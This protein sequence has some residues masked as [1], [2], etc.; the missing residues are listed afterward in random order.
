MSKH[1]VPLQGL[2]YAE[3]LALI[4]PIGIQQTVRRGLAIA[5][6][7]TAW[8]LGLASADD[9]KT[10][11]PIP[12]LLSQGE[13]QGAEGL[14]E[15]R[16]GLIGMA[17]Q[18][19]KLYPSLRYQ[20]GGAD[21]KKGG[22]DCSGS[23]YYIL[24]EYGL[25]PPRTSAGQ[26]EWVKAAGKLTLVPEGTTSLEAEVFARLKPGDLLFWSGTYTPKDGRSNK[27][28]H[29]QMY[30]GREKADGR[31]VMI[32]A[33]DG[34]SYRGIQRNGF[35]VFDFRLPRKGSKARIVGFGSPPG[36]AR[37]APTENRS[38]RSP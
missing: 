30:L 32:G 7:L 27:I 35:G 22:F 31:H 23:M 38:L 3:T 36:L 6:A 16:Q 5:I 24:G 15:R 20:Y 29:V 37:A 10:P 33:S 12:A 19:R 9:S 17:L 28:T 8:W 2:K 14:E 1:H 34:R 18:I 26:F 25:K 21:P 11:R 13:L 4:H